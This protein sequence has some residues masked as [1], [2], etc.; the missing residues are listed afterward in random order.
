MR[1]N[2]Q[3]LI[4]D[5]DDT[6]L[7]T[8]GQLLPQASKEACLAMIEG[9]LATDLASCLRVR[10]ELAQTSQRAQL[11]ETIVQRFGVKSG[12]HEKQ[13]AQAGFK[14]FY[15]RKVESSIAL[16][17]GVRDSLHD[18]KNRYSLHL[19]T[20]G[21]PDTQDEKLQIL[22]LNSLFE[23]VTVVNSFAGEEK[24]QAFKLIQ[25]QTKGLPGQYLSIGN[26]LD[27]DIAP[28]KRLGWATCWVKYGEYARSMPAHTNEEPDFIINRIQE[29][30]PTCQL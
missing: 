17:P 15:D 30:I 22:D 28:A 5:L 29:L 18:L 10:D 27:T 20:A 2:F 16:F 1:A 11:F 9:G 23:S 19:V 13:V 6:L 14:A 25:K 7:D 4:F 24:L 21:H 8:F 26:R 3:F 12:A